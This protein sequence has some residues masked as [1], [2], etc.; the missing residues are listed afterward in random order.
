V[1][2]VLD[3]EQQATLNALLEQVTANAVVCSEQQKADDSARSA[4]GRRG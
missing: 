3:S 1:L 4:A 2:A